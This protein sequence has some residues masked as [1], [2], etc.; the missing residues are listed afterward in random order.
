M[1]IHARLKGELPPVVIPVIPQDTAAEALNDAAEIWAK[2]PTECRLVFHDTELNDGERTL[3][4][5]GVGPDEVL[6]LEMTN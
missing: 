3:A 6:V 2:D 4:D 5:Y 1:A